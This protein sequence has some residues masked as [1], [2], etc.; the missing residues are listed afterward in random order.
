[1]I[2]DETRLFLESVGQC[3]EA[4]ALC[5]RRIEQLTNAAT[6]ITS[7]WK[8]VPGGGGG[9]VHK[10][11]VLI[12]LADQR[13]KLLEARRQYAAQVLAVEDFI[14]RIE[15]V[16]YQAILELRYVECL[17]WPLVI[18]QLKSLG[19]WYSATWVYQLHGK[20]LAAA[21]KLWAEEHKEEQNNG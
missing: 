18:E 13:A 20:E 14:S 15:S 17:P 1:M 2:R 5:T 10:D 8:D 3:R 6:R 9:D 11:D 7:A 12:A 19:M 21:R 16:A 4:E